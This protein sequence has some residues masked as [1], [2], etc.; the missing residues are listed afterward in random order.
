[1]KYLIIISAILLLVSCGGDPNPPL[2][3]GVCYA[4]ELGEYVGEGNGKLTIPMEIIKYDTLIRIGK[5]END[6]YITQD[7]TGLFTLVIP[8]NRLVSI[9]YGITKTTI[10]WR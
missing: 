4:Q 7:S 10:N 2:V 8:N 9:G 6:P 3:G 5:I 1:V